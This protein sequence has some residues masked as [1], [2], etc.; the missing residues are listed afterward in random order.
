M[1]VPAG[2]VDL[3]FIPLVALRLGPALLAQAGA[4]TCL[5][6]AYATA[7]AAP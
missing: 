5:T 2:A 1:K 3:V 6:Q 7:T 4:L